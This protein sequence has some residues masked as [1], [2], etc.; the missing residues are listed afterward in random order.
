MSRLTEKATAFVAALVDGDASAAHGMLAPAL[1]RDLSVADL[2][3]QFDTLA[4]DM[5][6]VTG[7]G[8]AVT[9]LEQWPG[10]AA[11]VGPSIADT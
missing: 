10:K 2:S 1:S 6:G 8:D 3:S 11:V 7:V 4:D 5:G 9:I